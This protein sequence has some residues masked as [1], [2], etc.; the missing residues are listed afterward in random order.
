MG[1]TKT[2]QEAIRRLTA[3]AARYKRQRDALA[4]ILVSLLNSSNAVER[5]A[6]RAYE[7][8]VEGDW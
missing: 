7:T 5:E 6:T 2:D 1:N 8:L 3:K 4:Q